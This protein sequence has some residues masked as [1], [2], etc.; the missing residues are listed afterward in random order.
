ML[1]TTSAPRTHVLPTTR[2]PSVNGAHP[3][4][5]SI[6]M[7]PQQYVPIG[8]DDG[9]MHAP[10]ASQATGSM[11]KVE[12]T[13]H[14][15]TGVK[16]IPPAVYASRDQDPPASQHRKLRDEWRPPTAEAVAKQA[17]K[18]ASKEIRTMQESALS[19]LLHHP[20]IRGMREL[21]T[22]TN[23]YCMVF[24]YVNENVLV[25]QTGNIKVIDCGLSNLYSPIARLSTFCR[26]LYF[27]ALELAYLACVASRH[28][29]RVL[30]LN[31]RLPLDDGPAPPPSA[32]KPLPVPAAIKA[33]S[34]SPQSDQVKADYSMELPRLPAPA[35][36]HHSRLS[37]DTHAVP[38]P[39]SPNFA[40][41]AAAAP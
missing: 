15:L 2:Q 33:N 34:R 10:A 9:E 5:L 39:T 8:G 32:M 7:V 14:E 28:A 13:Y 21:I 29:A 24:E 22:Y 38:P 41:A 3:R 17:S 4:P 23:H 20:Y 30:G 36:T 37:Y 25:S 11:G 35:S 27:A 12:L 18:G 31:G 40:A 19:M 26:P 1:T 16:V 6:P